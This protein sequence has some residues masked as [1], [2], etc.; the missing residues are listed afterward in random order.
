M[1]EHLTILEPDEIYDLYSI[2][3]FDKDQQMLFFDL[4]EVEQK[5]MQRFKTPL[6]RLYFILQLGY[7]KAKQQFYIFNL[8]EV[9]SDRDHL[10]ERY[11][12]QHLIPSSGKVSKPTRLA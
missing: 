8:E 12:A 3:V 9:A 5:A 10:R 6:S 4:P 11:F 7:F 2:P 1:A